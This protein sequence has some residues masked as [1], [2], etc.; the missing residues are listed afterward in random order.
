MGFSKLEVQG[1]KMHSRILKTVS[2]GFFGL[3]VIAGTANAADEMCPE[4][5]DITAQ[6][7]NQDRGFTYAANSIRGGWKGENPESTESYLDKVGFTSAAVRQIT[8]NGSPVYFVACDYEGE[9]LAG[10]RMSQRFPL[11]AK[12]V[13][14]AW[15]N[16][17]CSAGLSECAFRID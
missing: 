12:P 2:A 13:G 5:K 6:P 16:N 17:F 14:G 8:E 10:I 15:N 4:V 11:A 1:V 9:G 3:F 7:I